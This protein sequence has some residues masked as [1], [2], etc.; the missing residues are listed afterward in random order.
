MNSMYGVN[1]SSSKSQTPLNL[2]SQS[3]LRVQVSLSHAA[4]DLLFPANQVLRQVNLTGL[5]Q[6]G[7]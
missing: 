2:Q 1:L 4:V 7:G 6:M 5:F 3:K